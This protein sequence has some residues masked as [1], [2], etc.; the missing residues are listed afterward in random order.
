[1]QTPVANA[2]GSP[3]ILDLKGSASELHWSPAG[4]QLAVALAPTPLIDDHLMFRKVHIVDLQTGK[5]T[6]LNNPGKMG[7]LAWSPDGKLLAL[8]SA[9]DKHDPLQGRLW[10][11]RVGVD[12]WTDALPKF[13]GHVESI[14]WIGRRE[15][16]LQA[17]DG[18]WSA[19][20]RVELAPDEAGPVI[21]KE[22]EA[23]TPH[24]GVVLTNL[25][26]NYVANDPRASTTAWIGSS[27]KHPPEVFVQP[28]GQEGPRRRL[29]DSNPWLKD[30]AFAKQAVVKY[31]A[32]DGLELEGILVRP[33][34]EKPGQRYPLVLTVHGGPEAHISNGWVTLYHSLG[35]VGAARGMAVFYPN[36]RGST[37]RGVAFSMLGQK[38]AAGKEFDDLIDGVD[39][40]V[41]LGLVDKTKVG[42]TGGSYGGYAT[43][44]G[45]TYYSDRFAAGVMFVGISDWVS[46]SGTTDIPYE[47]NL[48]HHRKWLWDD[49]DY[50]AKSSPI[51]HID[52]AKTPLLIM[53][54]KADPRVHPSQ[55][56]EL[57]RH[58]KVRGKAPVRLV[59]Y[60]GEGHGNRRAASRLDYNL[61][62]LQWME[63]Y[64]QGPGGAAP[65]YEID[66]GLTP[67]VKSALESSGG[68]QPGCAA[69]FFDDGFLDDAA[70]HRFCGRRGCPCCIGP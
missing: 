29:T 20:G 55:S 39:H 36:Y 8:I 14:V 57:Y 5:A 62:L 16:L 31:K 53:H 3:K 47:M 12:G 33:L 41:K 43:A 15:L 27:A 18:V 24:A 59:L 66:H 64:L 11:H 70:P 17:A 58:L 6:N 13:A 54:G 4:D 46:C 38:E 1:M 67:P 23:W 52:K 10:V 35:Q 48:V 32:R 7:Q 21:V 28:Y 49:W 61:R 68:R 22:A 40:F 60:P 34:G 37:G 26:G 42:I 50:F 2:P 69:A 30:M 45:S 9:A 63:H 25:T 51:N 56:L 19:G 65:P 44:W